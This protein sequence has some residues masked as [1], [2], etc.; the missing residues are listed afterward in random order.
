MNDLNRATVDRALALLGERLEQT[1]VEP[2]TILVCGGASLIMTRMV[3]RQVTKDIDVVAFVR[4]NTAF[5]NAKPFPALLDRCVA[6]VAAML[7]LPAYWINP[8]PT[9]LLDA[10][11][12]EGIMDRVAEPR[13]YGSKLTILFIGRLDQI[14]F[15]VFAAADAGP[16]RHLEDLRE[17]N[18]TSDEMEMA[19]RWV[20]QQDPSE[21]FRL[22]LKD[23]LRKIG[24]E[25]ASE[26][27]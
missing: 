8:G 26:R 12:P 10:G 19:A 17:L 4:D 13:H 2:I 24:Y 21:G 16:G 6:E 9:S 20:M 27:L 18:P 11:L 1:S 7:Q 3:S 15:K 23:M 25:Q 22:M 5:E 14:H